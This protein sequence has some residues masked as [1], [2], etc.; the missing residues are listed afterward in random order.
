MIIVDIYE[1][2]AKV[3]NTEGI[4]TKILPGLITMLSGGNITKKNFL[5]LYNLVQMYLE[6][7]KN[8]RINDLSDDDGIIIDNNIKSSK[9]MEDN[10]IEQLMDYNNQEKIMII[11]EIL[12]F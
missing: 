9:K 2:I 3:V 1:E 12:I 10:F 5:K 8:N 7:I 4:A 6:R 11:M